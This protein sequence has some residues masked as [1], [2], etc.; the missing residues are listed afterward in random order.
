MGS[1]CHDPTRESFI[2]HSYLSS[3]TQQ[4]LVPFDNPS[5]EITINC[6]EILKFLPHII[7][8]SLCMAP[9]AH[10][11]IYVEN[12]GD[13]GW[14][15]CRIVITASRVGILL[16][17]IT[18]ITYHQ[19]IHYPIRNITGE[20]K[21]ILDAASKLTHMSELKCLCHFQTNAIQKNNWHMPPFL[22]R[23]RHQMNFVLHNK[24]YPKFFYTTIYQ[25][26]T[27]GWIQW[28]K[29]SAGSKF[30]LNSKALGNPSPSS[31]HSRSMSAI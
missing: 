6:L 25:K 1:I 18:M 9:L 16:R 4:R 15:Q 7:I 29:F 13:Q 8:F 14:T 31:R 5:G 17:D 27:A 24:R 3:T 12:A 20:D 28:G 23:C 26:D 30:H 21:N 11:L 22:Y 19:Y 10:I 2:W